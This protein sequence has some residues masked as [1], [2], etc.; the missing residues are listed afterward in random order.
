MVRHFRNK[1]TF[2]FSLVELLVA[3]VFTLI[4]MAGLASVFKAS[5]TSFYMSGETTSS[6]RRNRLGIDLLG[7]DINTAGMYLTDMALLPFTVDNMPPFWI[8]PNVPILNAGTND[9]ASA[10][11]LY[12]YMDEPLPFEGILTASP[13]SQT[14]ADMVLSGVS[15]VSSP[16][17]YEVD[18]LNA[19][20]ARMVK[21]GHYLIFKDFWEALYI[22]R[23]ISVNGKNVTVETGMTP[24]VG[25]TGSGSSGL[26]ARVNHLNNRTRVV[27]VNPAQMVKYKIEMLKLDP[28]P[29]K[30]N[31]VPCLVRYQAPYPYEG[32]FDE[33]ANSRT[34][35]MIT[36]NVSGFKVYLSVNGGTT[37]A[38]EGLSATGF[39]AGWNGSTGIR[40]QIDTQLSVVGRPGFKDTRADDHWFRRIPVLVRVDVTTRT[41]TM[42]AE[43]SAGHDELKYRDLFQSFIF[44]PRHFGLPMN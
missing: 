21:D 27:F 25:V 19:D 31:G 30:P 13:V 5:I 42:R 3:L 8:N 23:V 28:D 15:V 39:G 12:F 22:T 40:S 26:P 16:P 33:A 2:G 14:A 29:E 32:V 7:E 34:R 35:Q 18:C 9:P 1:N 11:E 24:N 44:V 43:F 41:A 6:A 10:D 37:W 4:L 20:Y 17:T 38:G 36:E